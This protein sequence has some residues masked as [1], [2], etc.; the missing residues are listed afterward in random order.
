MAEDSKS[1][2]FS[3][4]PKIR[5]RLH[6]VLG[7]PVLSKLLYWTHILFLGHI[8][9]F[10]LKPLLR[11][12]KSYI[13]DSNDFLKKVLFLR[14]LPDKIILCNLDVLGLYPKISHDESLSALCKQL[15]LRQE[16]YIT[17]LTLV[18]LT[19]VAL[20]KNIFTLK[21]K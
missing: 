2:R 3:L 7:Q 12:I 4:L 6:G 19:E 10:H 13:K 5:K 14:N 17:T 21:E 9:F 20:K 8:F 1:V 18:E 15:D 11:E 16:K